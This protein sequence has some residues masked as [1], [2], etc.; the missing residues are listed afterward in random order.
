M[1]ELWPSEARL[2]G[3]ASNRPVRH[4]LKTVVASVGRKGGSRWPVRS[5][6]S[7]CRY[8]DDGIL[9][10]RTE[11]EANRMREQLAVRLRECGLELHPEKTRVVYCKDSNRNGKHVNVQFDFLGY[12]FRPRFAESRAGARFVGSATTAVSIARH[13]W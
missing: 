8:A 11:A 2:Q 7:L 13:S 1:E 3:L 10:C 9:H 6:R 4:W 5:E 12:T